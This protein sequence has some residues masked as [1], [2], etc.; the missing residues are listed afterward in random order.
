MPKGSK[1]SLRLNILAVLATKFPESPYVPTPNVTKAT[2]PV[3]HTMAKKYK[4]PPYAKI[5]GG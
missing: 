2:L 3:T 1:V 4:S 5:P